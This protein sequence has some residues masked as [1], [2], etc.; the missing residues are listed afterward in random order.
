MQLFGSYTSPFV[1]HC[2]IVVIESGLTVE[3][4][5]TDA[6][7]S[8]IQ[9][10]TKRV[11]FLRDGDLSLTDSSSIVRYLRE[12]SGQAFLPRVEDLDHYCLINTVLEANVN[13]FF[14]E[15][16]GI[17]SEQSPYLQRQKGRVESTLEELD[18]LALPTQPPY[19][20][21]QLRL[22]CLLAWG[23][24]RKRFTVERLPH[25]QALLK[26]MD[27][28]EPFIATAPPAA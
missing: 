12:K 7:A 11:P 8:A 22:G 21:V 2:R 24:Y 1:R 14:L 16:E 9:S 10:P 23:R 5:E 27:D 28:Y 4:I 19:N 20:D 3:F 26:A 13:L 15:K 6:Q 18:K 25:L 17:T